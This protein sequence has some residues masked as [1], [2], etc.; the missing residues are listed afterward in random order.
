MQILA[1]ECV[2]VNRMKIEKLRE[3]GIQVTS[4]SKE[5]DRLEASARSRCCR[6]VEP[7]PE[8]INYGL[9]TKP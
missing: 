6:L 3:P 4:D 1:L 9:A 5:F 2:E 7:P 8:L